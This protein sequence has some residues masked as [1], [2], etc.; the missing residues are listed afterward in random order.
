M[1]G[2]AGSGCLLPLRSGAATFFLRQLLLSVRVSALTIGTLH[3]RPQSTPSSYN[4]VPSLTNVLQG[5]ICTNLLRSV[6]LMRV[7]FISMIFFPLRRTLWL[8]LIRKKYMLIV[9]K[10]F[11]KYTQRIKRIKFTHTYI[12]SHVHIHTHTHTLVL[13]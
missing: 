3:F 13:T 9:K 7:V 8:T 5:Y 6:L 2:E 4:E 1:D 12:H 11:G 10:N